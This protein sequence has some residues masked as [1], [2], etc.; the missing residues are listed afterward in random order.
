MQTESLSEFPSREELQKLLHLLQAVAA[1]TND[2]LF[3]K[4]TAGR[5]LYCNEAGGRLAGRPVD[6]IIG[7]D[8]IEIFGID[9][10]TVIQAQDRRVIDSTVSETEDHV[11]SDGE[12]VRTF[13]VTKSPYRDFSGNI[14]GVIGVARD[15]TDSR[16]TA[17][18]LRQSYGQLSSI[19]EAVGDV[20]FV[21]DVEPDEVFRF[22]SVNPAFLKKTGMSEND[23]VGKRIEQVFPEPSLSLTNYRRAV[24]DR[25]LVC[26]EQTTSYPAGTLIGEV[27]VAPVY[28][29][30]GNCTLLVGSVH[31]ISAGKASEYALRESESRLADAQKIARSGSWGWIPSSGEVWW[32]DAIYSLFGVDR[33]T[34]KPGLDVFLSLLHPDDRQ[35]A[36]DRVA[37]ML[38]GDS[39]FAN[40]MRLI[41]P[42]GKMIWLHS[43]ARATRDAAGNIVRVEGSDQDLTEQKLAEQGLRDRERLL[44]IVTGAARVGLVVVDQNY[45]HLF[46]NEAYAE[47]LGIDTDD[48]VAR[49]VFELLPEGWSQIKHRLD[50]A[51][52]GHR[53]EYE[54]TLPAMPGTTVPRWFHV[55][56]EPQCDDDGN[57]TVVVVVVDISAEKQSERVIR[58]S[59]ERYR[60]LM[61]VLPAAV[62][63]DSGEKIS[64]CN[65]AYVRMIGAENADA[66]LGRNPLDFVA[67]EFHSLAQSRIEQIRA[68]RIT[69]P[70]V[71]MRMQRL[72]GSTVPVYTVA[73]SIN[74]AGQ[75]AIL[76][77][78][79]DLTDRERTLNVLHSVMGSVSDAILTINMDGI[80]QMANPSVERL[81]GYS[82]SEVIGENIRI[83]MP[84]PYRSGHSDYL[85][86]F[87]RTG[88]AQV[89]GTSRE[90]E[91]KKKDGTVFPIE[92]TVTE[93]QV[94][95]KRQFT[96][97]IRNISNRKKLE[98]Q[99]QQSQKMEAIGRLAGGVAHDFN[100]LLTVING[101]SDL[102]LMQLQP[103]DPFV[104]PVKEIRD[105]GSRAARL[106]MQLLAFSR[107][108]LVKQ[109]LIDLNELIEESVSL[110]RR[111]IGEDITL[112]FVP[113]RRLAKVLA[114]PGQIEQVIMNLVV[115]AR[116][117]MPRGGRLT[118]QTRAVQIGSNDGL[119]F[120]D[121]EPGHYSELKV[122]DT[123]TGISP[124]VIG[125]VFEPFFTTREVGKG[126]GLGLAVA[127][128]VVKQC[129][130]HIS[131]ESS[132]GFGTTFTILL[133]A[134]GEVSTGPDQDQSKPATQGLETVLLVEDEDSVR[135]I[136]RIALEAQG[137][138]V[139]VAGSG[140]GAMQL[141]EEYPGPIELLITD[142]VMPGLGGRELVEAVQQIRP[143][144]RVLYI[145]GYTNDAVVRH[146]IQTATDNFLQKPF[147]PLSL[148]RKVRAVLD[149]H[150]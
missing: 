36:R 123:G 145:S 122:T 132:P 130:G 39:E 38:A 107:K 24:E 15:V 81:F 40:D 33:S 116:D 29:D 58:E 100:N 79:S 63:V 71:E 117:A 42:D 108:S 114:D 147:T 25:H 119:N 91:G 67:E 129:G 19:F 101:Y 50:L 16:K 20:V 60:Q 138:T 75:S 82:V 73:T 95:G 6:Q 37:A 149:Q 5:Y 139:L 150:L 118:C 49:R 27:T 104:T 69:V 103:F 7:S 127:H 11:I 53:V 106:T 32:S 62:F 136:A 13:E 18:Q 12:S 128:G 31:D 124:E 141:V 92:L 74:D 148:A 54:L 65:P 97:V 144:I 80:V 4:D 109:R 90:L 84:E 3:V 142:V 94:D 46:A 140:S 61:D 83:L 143:E 10:G 98:S 59:E 45:R 89:I 1:T 137:Y 28:S 93:F 133:P 78:V 121:L 14:S 22:R 64:Y 87:L 105:A 55:M 17:Q 9:A 135:R 146:G 52:M 77:V 44:R 72:D 56:Y 35:M 102:L 26:W 85:Q 99:V 30:D 51:L 134:I 23:V 43:R 113:D 41:R 111:L 86:N 88:V 8:D 110:L 47:I 115:N 34:T 125:K 21:L 120:P 48:F 2:A 112:S 76:V 68:S 96:G 57:P 131:V 70:P 126:T 66:L